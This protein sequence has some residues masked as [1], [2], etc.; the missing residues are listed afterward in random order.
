MTESNV[1]WLEI[2]HLDW[3]E[4]KMWSTRVRDNNLQLVVPRTLKQTFTHRFAKLLPK[5]PLII[6]F[7]QKLILLKI[8]P[9]LIL[10]DI[11]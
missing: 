1:N 5:V 2:I 11:S 3:E 4:G 8:N 10:F 6:N 9:I 7:L